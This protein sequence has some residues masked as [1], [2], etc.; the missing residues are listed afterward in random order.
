MGLQRRL[1]EAIRPYYGQR[2]DEED[3]PGCYLP[4]TWEAS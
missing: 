3:D 4:E 1:D 2:V